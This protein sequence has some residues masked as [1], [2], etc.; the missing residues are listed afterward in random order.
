MESYGER[1]T[2]TNDDYM[3]RPCFS[4]YEKFAKVK[5]AIDE[6]WQA[7]CFKML[8]IMSCYVNGAKR[9]WPKSNGGILTGSLSRVRII[10]WTPLK[11]SKKR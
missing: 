10:K 4:M 1:L 3:C 6:L 7:V 9:T 5:G 11:S 2:V 8:T